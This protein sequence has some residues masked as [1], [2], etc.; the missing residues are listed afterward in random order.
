VVKTKSL[1]HHLLSENIDEL[2]DDDA[3]DEDDEEDF[4]LEE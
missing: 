3:E 2:E 4:E 1:T